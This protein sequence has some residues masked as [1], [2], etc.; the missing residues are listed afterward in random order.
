MYIP[1]RDSNDNSNSRGPS[2]VAPSNSECTLVVAP[3]RPARSE[4]RLRQFALRFSGPNN[5]NS[6]IGQSRN[7][8]RIR[9]CRY[10]RAIYHDP[11][12]TLTQG[13]N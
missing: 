2:G 11:I 7:D 10:R 3:I 1:C 9:N 12:I 5:E 4:L 13:R 6:R 8:Y